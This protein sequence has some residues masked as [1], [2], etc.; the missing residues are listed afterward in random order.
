MSR[1]LVIGDNHEFAHQVLWHLGDIGLHLD[2]A[3]DGPAG[4]ARACHHPYDLIIL[5]LMAPGH[6]GRELCRRLRADNNLTP[7][8]MLTDRSS[9]ID[10]VLCLEAGAD[11][12]MTKP[13]GILELVAQVKAILRR[14]HQYSRVARP[15]HPHRFP[16]LGLEINFSRRE[17]VVRGNPVE[18]T[19]KEFDLLWHLARYPGHV[20]SRAQLLDSIWGNDHAGYEHTINS[21]INRLRNK[22][23]NNPAEPEIVRTVWGVG[24][25]F[26]DRSDPDSR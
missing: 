7:I 11:D 4:L 10:R 1:I 26:T 5:D 9:G 18:L 24:Y 23:E 22:I 20:F 25:K 15:S 21:H 17:V 6:G 12:C 8:L 14:N 3:A 2:H 19:P 16:E 13:F